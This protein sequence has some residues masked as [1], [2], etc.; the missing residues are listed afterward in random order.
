MK[1]LTHD[2]VDGCLQIEVQYSFLWFKYY[3]TFRLKDKVIMQYHG[4]NKYTR[5]LPYERE[6]VRQLMLMPCK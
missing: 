5:L 4:N 1:K 2:Y 6:T 3:K